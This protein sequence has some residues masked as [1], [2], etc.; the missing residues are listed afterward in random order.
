MDEFNIFFQRVMY[1]FIHEVRFSFR[2]IYLDLEAVRALKR[3]EVDYPTQWNHRHK[4]CLLN[5]L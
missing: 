1:S 5:R 4:S 3:L 2:Y